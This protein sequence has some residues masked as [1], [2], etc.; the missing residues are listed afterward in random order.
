MFKDRSHVSK[1]RGIYDVGMKRGE[2]YKT[3]PS[4][5]SR[6]GNGKSD[7]ETNPKKAAKERDKALKKKQLK[8]HKARKR[9]N[10]KRRIKVKTT[11]GKTGGDKEL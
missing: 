11:K 2:V 8:S 7:I 6:N 5:Q 10:K 4:V 1:K 9:Y 3:P